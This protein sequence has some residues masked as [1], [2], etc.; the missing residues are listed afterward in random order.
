MQESSRKLGKY[1]LIER[2][3]S[4]ATGTG[5]VYKA[6]Q[7]GVGRFVAIKV[8]HQHL[9][10]EATFVE[11]F[12]SQAR[13][14]GQLQHTNLVRVLDFEIQDDLHFMV[15]SYIQ[16]GT[17]REY[18]QKNG[19]L[20][21]QKALEIVLQ[22]ADGLAYA[23]QQGIMHHDIKPLNIMFTDASLSS[24]VLTDF[25]LA[26]M[27]NPASMSSSGV[28]IGTPAYMPPEFLRGE[29]GDEQSDIYSLAV[30]L[31]EMLT[32]SP[33]YK[34]STP[35][36]VMLRIENEA[37][38][39]LSEQLP[40]IPQEVE[41]LIRKGLA[42]EPAKRFKDANQF[43][44]A[45][46]HALAVVTGT[47]LPSS[48]ATLAG[49][50][51]HRQRET[52][53]PSSPTQLSWKI[54][55]GAVVAVSL[56]ILLTVIA[57]V[58]LPSTSN[59]SNTTAQSSMSEQVENVTAG[60][61]APPAAILRFTDN[62]EVRAGNARLDIMSI[63]PPEP[64][65]HYDVW[66]V[67]EASREKRQRH[68]G[69]LT[70]NEDGLAF[71]KSTGENLIAHYNQVLISVDPNDAA[72]EKISGE[73][74]F[75]GT[76]SLDLLSPLRELIFK[77]KITQKGFL[78]GA[79]EQTRLAIEQAELLQDALEDDAL[80]QAKRHAEEI[81]N[82]LNGE[83]GENFEDFDGNGK[84]DNSGDN[85]GVQRYLREASG[86][87]EQAKPH[88]TAKS[89]FYAQ[90]LIKAIMNG[91]ASAEDAEQTTLKLLAVDSPSEGEPLADEIIRLLNA[92]LQGSD[93]DGN[94]QVDWQADEG[95][96]LAAYDF[97]LLMAEI[98]IFSN[99]D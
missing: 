38:P 49:K 80:D 89:E 97:A 79:E 60:G 63:S 82:I 87:I 53:L 61:I 20:P 34:A 99:G 51:S 74:A 86:Q 48:A 28:L 78:L 55:A 25:G 32:G 56:I 90:Q 81:V 69:P 72:V 27:L 17:L 85:F 41:Q 7:P 21:V 24:P 76:L 36:G 47:P 2:L 92:L 12:R 95:A 77:D 37:L 4:A 91:Q 15:I 40:D 93:F 44:E 68:L 46:H 75:S 45:L 67:A 5:V 23:H 88:T 84:I 9:S 30:V 62:E 3:G 71:V 73:I 6:F 83:N 50:T 66:L 98:P 16:G 8:L 14:I 29:E 35:Y 1:E 64:D 42:K 57:L 18:L 94:G 65:T 43:Y 22:L 10:E 70:I 54:L 33:P 52:A 11:R 59:Q 96:I 31:Y 13:S 26:D 58:A 39:S 19:S